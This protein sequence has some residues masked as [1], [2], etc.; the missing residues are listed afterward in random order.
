[1][2]AALVISDNKSRNIETLLDR[3]ELPSE[4]LEVFECTEVCDADYRSYH[5]PCHPLP[6]RKI[7]IAKWTAENSKKP[8]QSGPSRFSMVSLESRE[9]R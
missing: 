2:N 8:T 1:M 4:V 6:K 3:S 5:M 7:S 9:E